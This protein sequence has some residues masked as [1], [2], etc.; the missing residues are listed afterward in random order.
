M[1]FLFIIINLLKLLLLTFFLVININDEGSPG[2]AF[3]HIGFFWIMF[4]IFLPLSFFEKSLFTS[5]GVS[6]PY[7]YIALVIVLLNLIPILSGNWITKIYIVTQCLG[8][9]LIVLETV[10][11]FKPGALK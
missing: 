10:L 6:D 9:A 1:T 4:L 3:Q 8:I 7:Q 5:R 2:W 11:Y